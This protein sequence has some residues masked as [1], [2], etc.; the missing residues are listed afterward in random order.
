MASTADQFQRAI[1]KLIR[2]LK[3][4]ARDALVTYADSVIGTVQDTRFS[5]RPALINRSSKLQNSFSRR[6][7]LLPDG[8]QVTIFSKG[9]ANIYAG[10]QEFGRTITPKNRAN[11]TV[12]LSGDNPYVSGGRRKYPTWASAIKA[13]PKWFLR[14]S[15]RD[16]SKVLHVRL[17]NGKLIR[18]F[19]LKK[20]V[21]VPPRLGLGKAIEGSLGDLR[22]E[23]ELAFKEVLG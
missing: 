12:P 3:R 19:V 11:L 5:G 15:K 22:K 6:G 14:P 1:E 18:P 8:A 4:P 17:A 7:K 16:G 2:G 23:V 13:G 21:K 20:S 9:K 10:T